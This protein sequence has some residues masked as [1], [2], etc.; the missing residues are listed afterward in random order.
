MRALD[1]FGPCD[2]SCKML[3]GQQQT[4]LIRIIRCRWYR[5][6]PIRGSCIRP[7]TTS[8]AAGSRAYLQNGHSV[9]R[10]F[11]D[12]DE[13]PDI[14]GRR[15]ACYGDVIP[16]GVHPDGSHRFV[17]PRAEHGGR[18]CLHQRAGRL[19]P[20]HEADER[21]PG[22]LLPGGRRG[23]GSRGNRPHSR[24]LPRRIQERDRR[25]LRD[26][27]R[28]RPGRDEGTGP[29]HRHENDQRGCRHG[30]QRQAARHRCA[31][32]AHV[33]D[34][35]ERLRDRPGAGAGRRQVYDAT[36]DDVRRAA[37]YWAGLFRNWLDNYLG[38]PE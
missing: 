22:N 19:Q 2:Q 20:V 23:A 26:R 34:G 31:R 37:E 18:I 25:C 5:A 24:L 30:R 16:A 8:T 4:K 38:E 36:W 28:A 15:R 17:Q 14:G 33:P 7:G 29:G 12:D 13:I 11:H 32:R 10:C 3:P 35:N 27:R 21:R 9:I 6:V 1:G